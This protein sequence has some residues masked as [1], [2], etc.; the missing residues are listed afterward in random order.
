MS[1]WS[2]IS[3]PRSF[4]A[5]GAQHPCAGGVGVGGDGLGTLARQGSRCFARELFEDPEQ[6]G[7]GTDQ[8]LGRSERV[9]QGDGHRRQGHDELLVG[10]LVAAVL[11]A[12][13]V[14][15]LREALGDRIEVDLYAPALDLETI[16]EVEQGEPDAVRVEGRRWR[17]GLVLLKQALPPRRCDGGRC[18][19]GDQL[20]AQLAEG[21]GGR[22]QQG[23][24]LALAG[25]RALQQLGRCDLVHREPRHDLVCAAYCT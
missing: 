4:V 20:T 10:R 13:G 5:D 21:V 3:T 17:R 7:N 14:S 8:V 11:A 1:T 15:Q 25:F 19:G 18:A 9:L 16:L 24:P 6:R 22:A 2:R 23:H 12:E